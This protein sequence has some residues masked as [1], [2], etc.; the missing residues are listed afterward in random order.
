MGKKVG[1][2]YKE[3][4]KCRFRVWSPSAEAV[5]VIVK[6]R[7]EGLPLQQ[8]SRGYWEGT[9]DN[10]KPGALY[11]FQLN[12]TDEFPDP[13][14]RSQPDGVHSW[15]QVVD[16]NYYWKDL[17]WK[18]RPLGEMLIYELHVGTFTSQGTFEAIINKLDHLEELGI[19]TIEIMPI[20][21]F[22]GSRNWGYDGVYPFAA[23]D[24]Y[25]G[26]NGLKKLIDTCHQRGFSVLLDVV[27]NHL[28]PEGNYLSQFG[29]SFTDKYNTPWGSS[30]NFDVYYSFLYYTSHA[31]TDI[32]VVVL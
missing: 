14:S 5:E 11:K 3:N 15:S 31:S 26:V 9:I 18:G 24:S 17:D 13:A 10:V 28:G 30:I 32:K 22:P 8:D 23:Q 16:T 4:G 20:S 1:A 6:D 12:G 25:G 29:P 19:N 27:Y 7:K 21:Q 2:E